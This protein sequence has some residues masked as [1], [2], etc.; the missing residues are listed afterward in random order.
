MKK[1]IGWLVVLSILLGG[2]AWWWQQGANK[3]KAHVEAR[4]ATLVPDGAVP[5][6]DHLEVRGFPLG[7]EVLLT[8]PKVQWTDKGLGIEYK[9]S[10]EGFW[11]FGSSLLTD[12]AW[13]ATSGHSDMKITLTSREGR[14]IHWISSGDLKVWVHAP[15]FMDRNLQ[16]DLDDFFSW[17]R[18]FY[19]GFSV[20]AQDFSLV[21]G[22]EPENPPVFKLKD[23]FIDW[24]TARNKGLADFSFSMDMNKAEFTKGNWV[25]SYDNWAMKAHGT[26][27]YLHDITALTWETVP[28]ISLILD[29]SS[30]SSPKQSVT[31]QGKL[32]INNQDSFVTLDFMVD[33]FSE[34]TKLWQEKTLGMLSDLAQTN[35]EQ[36]K[37]EEKPL[38]LFLH[39][40]ISQIQGL[41]P[42]LSYFGKTRTGLEVH[43]KA[44]KSAL[45]TQFPTQIA[46]QGTKLRWETERYG[47]VIQDD[48]N[49]TEG[50]PLTG[51]GTV[52]ISHYAQL[53]NDLT[54]YGLGWYRVWDSGA[55]RSSE[56]DILSAAT[57][58]VEK[59]KPFLVELSDPHAGADR[60]LIKIDAKDP[61]KIMIGPLSAAEAMNRLLQL[62][63]EIVPILD[64]TVGYT[65]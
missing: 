40:H 61:E 20:K 44:L 12:W 19:R 37:P 17:G 3:I 24:N 9:L 41:V 27:P 8:N 30:V 31:G 14:G 63:T 60:L 62:L 28:S 49:Y 33:S 42:D 11:S 23:G 48:M 34:T 46:L 51:S 15:D 55:T 56:P 53:L 7:Y 47:I 32:I 26:V 21:N 43:A 36:V 38:Y 4:L 16:W 54:N 64:P 13:A 5:T 25:E 59:I 35:L 57:Q 18:R 58:I 52:E 10:G 29:Q 65:L 22:N 2:Y 45:P 1:T 50:L 6:Y 39:E